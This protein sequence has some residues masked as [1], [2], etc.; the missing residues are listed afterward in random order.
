[1]YQCMS[2]AIQHEKTRTA[3]TSAALCTALYNNEGNS[4]SIIKKTLMIY[5]SHLL[6]K[7]KDSE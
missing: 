6:I 7:V 5:F 1:M 4:L 3:C 2:V